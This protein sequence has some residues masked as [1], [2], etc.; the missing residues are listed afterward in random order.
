MSTMEDRID[1][2]RTDLDRTGLDLVIAELAA[3][4]ARWAVMPLAARA[5]LLARTRASVGAEAARWV[6]AAARAKGLDD[7]S[8]LIGE[9]WLTG[10][11][12][13]LTSLTALERTV[14]ALAAGRSP[15]ARRRFGRAP[16][17][18]VTVAVLPHNAY[19][20][21]FLHGFRADSWLKPGV[22]AA[23]AR[24]QAGLGQLAP[25]T[26]GGIGLVLGAGNISSI[27]PLDVL[28]ELV[29]HNRVSIL[30]LNPTF[31][32]LLSV[33]RAALAPLIDA[34]LLHIV[35]GGA[36]VGGYL[37]HHPGIGHVHITGSAATHDAIALGSTG[38]N[39]PRLTKPISSE[40]GGVSPIIVLPG[41]WSARDLQYQAEHVATMRLHNGGYN[42]IAGQVLVLSATWPQKTAFLDAVAT[43][44]AAAP[45]RTAWY[46]GSEERMGAAR[47]A[48]PG[49]RSLAGGRLLVTAADAALPDAALQKS[50][51]PAGR[52]IDT[53]KNLSPRK[54]PDSGSDRAV[55]S[56]ST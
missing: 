51:L 33:Y 29:A 49:A 50:A 39:A 23:R 19:D 24:S 22:T 52:S 30:K 38:T 56:G 27:A 9:E 10:P 18:R 37:A 14:R 6:A 40:L 26:S 13:V 4:S 1:L 15:I 3:G 28:Y 25:T 31:D 53:G 17:G 7:L 45:A 20:E 16:G 41:R 42:C 46:P 36:T 47:A 8:P 43:A 5:D 11:Y 32:G 2:D 35:T 48:Y 44:M 55:K 34:G 54:T 21:V 12:S